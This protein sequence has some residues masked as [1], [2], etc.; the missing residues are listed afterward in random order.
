MSTSDM[1]DHRRSFPVGLVMLGVAAVTVIAMAGVQTISS[2]IAPAFFGLTMIVTARPLIVWLRKYLHL[3]GW[4]ATLIMLLAIY[5]ILLSIIGGI[6]YG[7]A[8]TGQLLARQEYRETYQQM[9]ED[10]FA[11]LTSLGL[12]V[13]NFEQYLSGIDFNQILGVVSGAA[14]MLT[15]GTS[16]AVLFVVV[17]A[18]MAF[19]T[20]NVRGRTESLR[21]AAPY[22]TDAL[23]GFSSQVRKY[24]IVSTVFGAI[25]AIGDGIALTVMDVPLA[26]TFALFAFVTN[27]IP[28]IGFF[29]GLIP[30]A[31]VGLLDGGVSTMIW[32]IV[33]YTVINNGFQTFIQPKVTG[34]AVG[35]NSAVTFLSLVFWTSIVGPLGSILAVPLT[36]FAKAV[37]IDSDPRTKV[38]AVFLQSG[39]KKVTGTQTELDASERLRA[40]RRGRN[41]RREEA[42]G[43]AGDRVRS[44]SDEI[45]VGELR[46]ARA[47]SGSGSGGHP[48]TPT[49][50]AVPGATRAAT[51]D[52]ATAWA[53][54]GEREGGSGE[55]A[56]GGGRRAAGG[57][58]SPAPT[59]TR[60]VRQAPRSGGPDDRPA[61]PGP[62]GQ[63][64]R[65]DA[66]AGGQAPPRRTGTTG[67]ARPDDAGTAAPGPDDPR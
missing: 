50:P 31:L 36:L 52:G 24:W 67:P 19:D 51:S 32:I 25:V 20:I 2:I 17:T 7:V 48:L 14:N 27:Y 8:E 57:G 47:G 28:N 29:I 4:L 60:P 33:I 6:A 21:E 3:P 15:S 12:D 23:T 13:S 11:W 26:W 61:A 37:L 34:D 35:L 65:P 38:F 43:G 39:D 30:P 59:D 40:E 1:S 54:D 9:Y 58:R 66:Q 46:R 10:S 64:P 16:Q 45:T 42:N 22:L 49:T 53:P 55:R 63:Q 18:F 41:A 56:A 5:L 44:K 62:A